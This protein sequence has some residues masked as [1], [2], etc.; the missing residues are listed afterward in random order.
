MP[1]R[2]ARP[3]R[4]TARR[5][6]SEESVGGIGTA[7]IPRSAARAAEACLERKAQHGVILDLRRI[8]NATDYFVIVSGESD[9]HVRAI[10]EHILESVEAEGVRPAGVEG[11]PGGRWVLIDYIDAVIHVFHPSARDYYQLERLWGDA[12]SWNLRDPAEEP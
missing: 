5:S 8:S 3:A 12:P 4:G 6:S 11:L 7:A 2:E 10:A 9:T 1:K